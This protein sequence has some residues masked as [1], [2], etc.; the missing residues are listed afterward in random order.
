MDRRACPGG[1]A[2]AGAHGW[3]RTGVTPG[4]SRTTRIMNCRPEDV[5]SVLSDGWLYGMWVVGSARIRDVDAT[6]PRPGAKIHHSVGAWPVLISDTSE[7]DRFDEPHL[8]ELR[9]RA[10]PAGEAQV[11]LTCTP[12]D[13]D[14]VE[15]VME[16]FPVSGPA[17][18]IPKPLES[19]LLHARNT[20]ALRR[21]SFLAEHGA[22]SGR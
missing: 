10:W 19:R 15:V 14:R 8:I 22:R 4:M 6:W 5:F 21:L 11:I 9:V 1:H 12:L 16:E 18:L 3:A 13:D 7:V 2:W 20:E 17:T